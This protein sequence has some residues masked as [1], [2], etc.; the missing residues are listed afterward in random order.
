MLT[1]AEIFDCLGANLK[2]ASE[3]CKNLAVLPRKGKSHKDLITQL[4]LI[5][6]AARQAA[7]WRL[8]HRWLGIGMQCGKAHHLAKN[9]LSKY[10]A[11]SD[12]AF[13]YQLFIKLAEFLDHAYQIY[14]EMKNAKTGTNNPILPEYMERRDP[15]ARENTVMKISNGGI[16]IPE[17]VNA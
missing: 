5:E 16:I 4:H 7:Y 14:I 9:W 2:L 17:G 8:D 10:R 15:R 3:N 6:G 12:K 11:P 1:E 13:L